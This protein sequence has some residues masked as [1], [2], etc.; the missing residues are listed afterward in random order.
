MSSASS[1]RSDAE[2]LTVAVWLAVNVCVP[3]H[4]FLGMGSS[5]QMIA[6]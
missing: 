1:R 6:E 2:W 4:V 3:K 5:M